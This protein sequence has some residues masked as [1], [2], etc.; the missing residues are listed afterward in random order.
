MAVLLFQICFL[1]E[2]DISKILHQIQINWQY[3]STDW[4]RCIFCWCS[5]LSFYVMIETSSNL[6]TFEL[7]IFIYLCNYFC[8]F[9]LFAPSPTARE[10][11]KKNKSN[12]HKCAGADRE[13]YIELGDSLILMVADKQPWIMLD[14]G[15]LSAEQIG[16]K[17][18]RYSFNCVLMQLIKSR[19][20]KVKS[21]SV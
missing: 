14:W 17:Y 3:K 1:G 11:K 16:V 21:K 10:K 5:S 15:F 7:N 12:H 13:L 20:L 8:T 6:R 9:S 19:V 4:T 2:F 18:T